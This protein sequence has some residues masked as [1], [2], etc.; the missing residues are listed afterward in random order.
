MTESEDLLQERAAI[1]AEGNGWTQEKAE[2]T[3]AWMRGFRG[4]G[5]LLRAA[6][7]RE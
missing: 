4:W 6:R 7:S 1:M 3:L 2:R 5:E